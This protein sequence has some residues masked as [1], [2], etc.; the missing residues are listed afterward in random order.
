MWLWV[1]PLVYVMGLGLWLSTKVAATWSRVFLTVF[2]WK[3]SCPKFP[4]RTACMKAPQ[5][6]MFA[7]D[8]ILSRYGSLLLLIMWRN[9]SQQSQLRSCFWWV[10][11][12]TPSC[13]AISA[14]AAQSRRHASAEVHSYWLVRL[15]EIGAVRLAY[16]LFGYLIRNCLSWHSISGWVLGVVAGVP[17]HHVECMEYRYLIV[18]GG[19]NL[20]MIWCT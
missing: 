6:R 8:S 19:V 10:A 1:F 20:I 9:P 17:C 18:N 11:L 13:L 5:K 15:N 12:V 16:K 7:C 3:D 2:P 4:R 14:L